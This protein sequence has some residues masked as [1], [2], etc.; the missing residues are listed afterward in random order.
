MI[1]VCL[2]LPNNPKMLFE[3]LERTLKDPKEAELL[4]WVDNDDHKTSSEFYA[5]RKYIRKGLDVK[6]FIN[7]KAETE[8]KVFEFLE[9]QASGT[10]MLRVGII[11]GII[12]L[13]ALKQG[14]V[15]S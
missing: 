4:L 13:A 8:Q 9:S 10:Q 5:L 3:F 11:E 1:S 12:L 6:V 15:T 2:Y 14:I 7:P